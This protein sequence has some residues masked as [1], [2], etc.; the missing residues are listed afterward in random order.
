MNSVATFTTEE[1]FAHKAAVAE[2][3]KLI[4]DLGTRQKH[5][6]E[7]LKRLQRASTTNSILFTLYGEK[8]YL[9]RDGNPTICFHKE[10][11]EQELTVLHIVYNRLRRRPPHLGTR[12]NDDFYLKGRNSEVHHAPEVFRYITDD[13]FLRYGKEAV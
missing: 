12:S 13:L 6:K 10:Y 1:K 3:K 8:H 11:W 7:T 2:I 5:N 4:T 9:D